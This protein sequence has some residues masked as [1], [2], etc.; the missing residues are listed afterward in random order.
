MKQIAEEQQ[1]KPLPLNDD[2]SLHETGF[3][4]AWPSPSWS[5][6]W[7]TISV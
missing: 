5:R 3:D 1:V 2:L 6:A 7:K 4:L